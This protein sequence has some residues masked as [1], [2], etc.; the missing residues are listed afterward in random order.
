MKLSNHFFADVVRMARE[1]NIDPQLPRHRRVPRRLDE[2]SQPHRYDSPED[3]H[4][5]LDYQACDL[6]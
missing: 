6:L 4:R 3:Y 5:H 2:G 1:V